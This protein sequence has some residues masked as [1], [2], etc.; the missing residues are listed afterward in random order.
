MTLTESE[1]P[2]QKEFNDVGGGDV[3]F[4]CAYLGDI[5]IMFQHEKS[6]AIAKNKWDKRK[7]RINDSNIVVVAWV[8]N[9]ILTDDVIQEFNKLKYK[10]VMLT[11]KNIKEED[12]V[13]LNVPSNK[14]W[15]QSRNCYMKYFEI[16]K[17]RRIVN[18]KH[19]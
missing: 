13:F 17:W 9:N 8:E 16:F 3:N 7:T 12:I 14:E 19:N 4:P 11:N 1:E 5:K 18:R 6:F 15:W 10:K 2:F